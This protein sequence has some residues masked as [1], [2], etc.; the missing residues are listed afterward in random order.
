MRPLYNLDKI[1]LAAREIWPNFPDA[2]FLFAILPAAKDFNY[3]QNVRQILGS[4]IGNRA[5][6]LDAIPHDRM[7]DYYRLADVTISIP[8]SDGTPMSVLESLA[9]GTPVIV[10]NIPNYDSDYIEAEKTVLVADPHDV[11]AVVST[12]TRLLKDAELC[13][14]LATEGRQR[15][16]A[17]GSYEAQMGH[18]EDLYYSL[19]DR[20]SS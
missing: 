9:C 14:S 15:V 7:P 2:Y 19:V 4:E 6:F 18:M 16:A 5:R 12:L 8:S 3:E 11:N 17:H 1:A 20:T 13:H 10:S